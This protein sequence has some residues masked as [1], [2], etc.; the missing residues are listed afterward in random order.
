[1][2]CKGLSFIADGLSAS[3]ILNYMRTSSVV[4]I[5]DLAEPERV[6]NGH[7][8]ITTKIHV[9]VV[10]GW[11]PGGGL[12]GYRAERHAGI[13]GVRGERTHLG[14]CLYRRSERPGRDSHPAAELP[15]PG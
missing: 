5:Q 15:Q 1:M 13:G 14:L 7:D 9:L 12:P 3:R 6:G 8:S 2:K 4:I 10:Y 11:G